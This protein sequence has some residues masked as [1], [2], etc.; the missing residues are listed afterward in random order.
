VPGT[1]GSRTEGGFPDEE[2]V[3]PFDHRGLALAGTGLGTGYAYPDG[4][5]VDGN[6]FFIT[7]GTGSGGDEVC[8]AHRSRATQITF[9]GGRE[10]SPA[11]AGH[12]LL[13]TQGA[14]SSQ[15]K[16][17]VLPLGN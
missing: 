9:D 3:A 16:P 4:A 6:D 10:G 2:K 14:N 1:G 17:V 13:Y 7:A 12:N 15:A 11:V 5:P 8:R